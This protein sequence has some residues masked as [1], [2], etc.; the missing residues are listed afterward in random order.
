MRAPPRAAGAAGGWASRRPPSY[1]LAHWLYLRGDLAYVEARTTGDDEPVPQAPRFV[2]KGA[3]GA[4]LRGFSVE[5]GA[6]HLGERYASEEF[7][8]PKLS[9]Y[10]VLDLGAAYRRG[11]FEVG[12]AVENLTA[13][14][15]RSSEFFFASSV[16]GGPGIEDFHFTP[17]NRR[18]VRGW[19]RVIF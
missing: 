16:D 17:G 3:V 12:L 7:N 4:R 11:P 6:R 15:W 5:L 10:T 19:V 13:T 18:N 1:F 2:A 8:N 14:K 9:D